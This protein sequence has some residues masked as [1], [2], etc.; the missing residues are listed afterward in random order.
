ML[1]RAGI[2]VPQRSGRN[3]NSPAVRHQS[4]HLTPSSF[5]PNSTRPPA[6][7]PTNPEITKKTVTTYLVIYNRPKSDQ[8]AARTV[9]Q[10]ETQETLQCLTLARSSSGW[11]L[12]IVIN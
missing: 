10:N 11:V 3:K 2:H 5:T 8:I 7:L 1:M 9:S 12:G 6:R 4:H